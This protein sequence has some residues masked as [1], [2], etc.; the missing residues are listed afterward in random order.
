MAFN[1]RN[2]QQLENKQPDEAG[3]FIADLTADPYTNLRKLAKAHGFNE[4]AVRGFIRRMETRYLPLQQ[5]MRSISTK[6]LQNT[7]DDRLSR[8]LDYMDDYV[9]AEAPLRELAVAFGVLM[10]KRQLL[11]GEPTQI[12]DNTERQSIAELLQAAN[13]EAERR[14]LTIDITPFNVE[15][16]EGSAARV[17]P[18]ETIERQDVDQTHRRM[19]KQ[20]KVF[21]RDDIPEMS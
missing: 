9:I 18:R 3:Q 19:E 17:L 4:R 6:Q 5:E 15:M 2:K 8:I 7:I 20:R 13:K 12:I 1:S 11:R 10:E 14:G 16:E 21:K